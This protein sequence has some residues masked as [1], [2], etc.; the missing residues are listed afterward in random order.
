MAC[1]RKFTHLFALI[2]CELR[3]NLLCSFEAEAD[4]L[5]KVKKSVIAMCSVEEW[6]AAW[7]AHASVFACWEWTPHHT[8]LAVMHLAELDLI[9][10]EQ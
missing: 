8:R 7:E 5:E 3:S 1:K 4:W 10:R 6:V 9:E 2:T